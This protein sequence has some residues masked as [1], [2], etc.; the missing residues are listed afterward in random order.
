MHEDIIMKTLIYLIFIVLTNIAL[1]NLN[2]HAHGEPSLKTHLVGYYYPRNYRDKLE[3]F[4]I[5]YTEIKLI[6]GRTLTTNG[7]G[8]TKAHG[9]VHSYVDALNSIFVEISDG[10][11]F[12]QEAVLKNQAWLIDIFPEP[13]SMPW[14][15][16]KVAH[17]MPI[18]HIAKLRNLAK[19]Y[20][21]HHYLDEKRTVFVNVGRSC[22][23]P[24]SDGKDFYLTNAT[25]KCANTA[26][27][28]DSIYYQW[29]EGLFIETGGIIDTPFS[30]GFADII[31]MLMTL[32]SKIGTGL[33]LFDKERAFRDLKVIHTYPK[34]Q[35]DPYKESLIISSA[36]WRLLQEFSQVYGVYEAH[37]LTAELAFNMIFKTR[38][39]LGVYEALLE[40]ITEKRSLKHKRPLECL[41]NK[42]F[43]SH[44]LAEKNPNCG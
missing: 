44:G 38:N 11:H 33:F 4:S 25:N 34:D 35:G 22:T 23:N 2:S 39:Y 40:I 27:I 31:T 28:A 32:D 1:I 21:D 18:Y 26:L 12:F 10:N 19:Q 29:A 8:K 20:I 17:T 6:D 37:N 43:M 14:D 5:P 15:D 41:I 9:Q 7:R 24:W 16:A 30:I 42:V 3:R 13:G 36:F